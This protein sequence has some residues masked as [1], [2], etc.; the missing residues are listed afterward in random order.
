MSILR[1]RCWRNDRDVAQVGGRVIAGWTDMIEQ[2]S[3]PDIPRPPDS[4]D[5]PPPDI[6]PVP[7]PDI[8]PPAGPPDVQLPTG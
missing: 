8:P 6:K 1:A 4:I 3:P 7:P 5:N 2:P